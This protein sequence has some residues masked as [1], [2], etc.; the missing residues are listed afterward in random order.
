M[1]LAGLNI[2]VER[3]A[4]KVFCI[5]VLIPLVV[6]V[7]YTTLF[8]PAELQMRIFLDALWVGVGFA[9]YHE[10]AQLVHQLGHALAA[11]ATGYP[12]TGVRYEWGFSYS[13]YPPDEPPLPDRV[14]I[15]R[16]L[17]GVGGITLLLVIVVLLWLQVDV[18]ASGFTRWLLNFLLFDSV[19][20]FIGSAVFSDGLLFLMN[21]DWKAPQPNA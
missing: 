11:Q 6:I 5:L 12:M 4:Y 2:K 16:S 10:I 18:T 7:G 14:H 21:Q 17:G 3:S 1:K 19:L 15:Q 13:E 20:L 9:V 8:R